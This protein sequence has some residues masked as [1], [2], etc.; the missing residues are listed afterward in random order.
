MVTRPLCPLTLSCLE[1]YCTK[2]QRALDGIIQ[3]QF[4]ATS[5][6]VLL[7][8]LSLVLSGTV[9]RRVDRDLSLADDAPIIS[10]A[11]NLGNFVVQDH[12]L[13]IVI[14]T[15]LLESIG[16]DP[17]LGTSTRPVPRI[18]ATTRRL[19]LIHIRQLVGG[20]VAARAV[21]AVAGNVAVDEEA[22]EGSDD[23]DGGAEGGDEVFGA[24]VD[25]HVDG[26]VD[27]FFEGGHGG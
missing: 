15:T 5:R 25:E 27:V 23:G 16:I 14:T 20:F 19:V 3:N 8:H 21:G 12:L 1:R 4:A 9:D 10:L 24:R 22:P 17:R 11:R 18:S 7:F 2:P 26:V 6:V 13:T